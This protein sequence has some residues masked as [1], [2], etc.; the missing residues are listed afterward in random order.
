MSQLWN[1]ADYQWQRWVVNYDSLNQ[2][3]FLASFG[4]YDFK[5]MMKWAMILVGLITVVL[6]VFLLYQ[7]QKTIDPVFRLYQRYCKK[8][9]LAGLIRTNR[10]GAV[11]FAQRAKIALPEQADAIEQITADFIQ[12]RYGRTS[13]NEDFVRFA[14]AVAG[15]KVNPLNP[16]IMDG[17]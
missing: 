6:S 11:D 17:K 8:L 12:L 13:T 4:I 3:D 16:S 1:N 15:F 10:E 2:S 7:K 14:K 9:Q 5:A